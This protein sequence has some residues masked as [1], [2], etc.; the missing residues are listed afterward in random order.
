MET[1]EKKNKTKGSGRESV[2]DR[3]ESWIHKSPKLEKFVENTSYYIKHPSE[4]NEKLNEIYNKATE[5]SEHHT[6][7]DFAGKIKSVYRM[8]KMSLD[9]EYQGIPKGQVIMGLAAFGYLISPFDILPNDVLP[10]VGFVD[11]A[12]LGFW[13]IKNISEEVEKFEQWERSQP[14]TTNPAY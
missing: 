9:G 7:S 1:K 13:L 5:K 2:K 12:A 10:F 14:A 6:L 8:V 3:V 11:E 4:F